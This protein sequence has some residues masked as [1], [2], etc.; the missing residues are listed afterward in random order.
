MDSEDE[1]ELDWSEI[2]PGNRHN[3]FYLGDFYV[4][5]LLDD[6]YITLYLK[7]PT[8]NDSSWYLKLVYP[9]YDGEQFKTTIKANRLQGILSFLDSENEE[10]DVTDVLKK[11]EL[12]LRD[13][14]IRFS[15]KSC[16]ELEKVLSK[17]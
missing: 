7:Q 16:Q 11:L 9:R 10:I 6:G 4:Q 15:D 2:K 13:K 14:V 8:L 3:G 5:W 12:L 1:A 17:F